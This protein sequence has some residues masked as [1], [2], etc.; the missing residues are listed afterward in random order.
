MADGFG[1]PKYG[2]GGGFKVFDLKTEK[3]GG[4]AVYTFRLLPPM[5]SCASTGEWGK[6]LGQH[7]GYA[8]Q[9]TKDQTKT[10]QRPFMCIEVKNFRSKIVTQSCPE[11]DL[12]ASNKAAS[13]Q[14]IVGFKSDASLAAEVVEAKIKEEAAWFKSHNCQRQ[15]WIN[16]MN[17]QG[18]FGVLRISHE[19][20]KMLDTK[21]KE[22]IEQYQIDPLD[23][24]QGVYFKFTRAGAGIAVTTSV[25]VQ[26]EQEK[27]AQGRMQFTIKMAPLSAAQAEKALAE[28]PDL[29]EVIRVLSEKQVALL[30]QCSGDPEEVDAIWAMGEKREESPAPTPRLVPKAAPAPVPVPAPTPAPAPVLPSPK[31]APAPEPA[32]EPP[33]VT[34]LRKAGL[35]DAQIAAALAAQ[36]PATPAPVPDPTPL[37]PEVKAEHPKSP[38][39][40]SG[41]SRDKFMDLFR[42]NKPKQ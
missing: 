25:E 2:G 32:V 19:V 35:N 42:D 18:E 22:L 40:P 10:K 20:K 6:Y 13:D 8:G 14:R 4:V 28:C 12:I 23:L 39:P 5:K 7:F 30:T 27:N 29:N 38:E 34:M 41:L 17:P 11:C 37:P 31:P 36:A 1:K 33:L 26:M 3:S 21:I 24:E 9:D 16:V 15:W